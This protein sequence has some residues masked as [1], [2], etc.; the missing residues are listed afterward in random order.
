M[1]VVEDKDPEEYGYALAH[2]RLYKLIYGD[3]LSDK[4]AFI[5]EAESD[6]STLVSEWLERVRGIADEIQVDACDFSDI[7]RLRRDEEE[8]RQT[9]DFLVHQSDLLPYQVYST[10]ELALKAKH[11]G[12]L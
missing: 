5:R 11:Q 6:N 3:T 10:R 4:V 2:T 8:L 1:I 12:L 7:E 9:E